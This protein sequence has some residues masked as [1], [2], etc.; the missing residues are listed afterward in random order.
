MALRSSGG[1]ARSGITKS[2]IVRSGIAK[3]GIVRSGIAKSENVRNGIAKSENVGS[4]ITKGWI[5][6]SEIVKSEN[7]RSGIAKGWIAKSRSEKKSEC[8]QMTGAT[9]P[10]FLC[11][12]LRVFSEREAVASLSVFLKK[13]YTRR[14]RVTSEK[15]KKWP[16]CPDS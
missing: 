14:C 11:A 15:E 10:C 9:G 8:V 5:V 6:R 3:S 12:E 13:E 16:L 4:G 7:V 1:L 2:E